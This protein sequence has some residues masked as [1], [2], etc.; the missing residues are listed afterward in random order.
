MAEAAGLVLGVVALV[1]SFKDCL[2]LF[3]Y[4]SAAKS[5]GRDY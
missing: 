5:V 2:D 4:V 1:G 3:L